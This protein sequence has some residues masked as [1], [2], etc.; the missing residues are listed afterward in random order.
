MK[1]TTY[2][3]FSLLIPFIVWGFCIVLFFILAVFMPQTY[4]TGLSQSETVLESI[5]LFVV[6]YVLGI[7]IWIFPYG[8]LALI[9]L[10]WSFIGRAQT[11]LRL[12]ALSPLAMTA[13]TTAVMIVMDLGNVGSDMPF[14][15]P[16]PLA[17]DFMSFNVEVAAISLVWG[18]I[19]VGIGYG[20]YKLLQRHGRINDDEVRTETL[21]PAQPA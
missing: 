8:L 17:P 1:T 5:I 16:E 4:G 11:M 19:C 14:S 13:L 18:Y 12:F 21:M 2:L 6:Y 20:I 7:F 15:Q 10:L 3:R 9:L